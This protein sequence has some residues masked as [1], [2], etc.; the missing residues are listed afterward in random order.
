MPLLPS[1][2]ISYYFSLYASLVAIVLFIRAFL[3]N[4]YRFLLYLL[5]FW[6]FLAFLVSLFFP[7]SLSHLSPPHYCF[8]FLF[9]LV[10]H[11]FPLTFVS[12]FPT[13]LISY[14]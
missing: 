1:I 3:A 6:V 13:P 11:T 8:H 12:F 10:L 4:L 5:A 7:T 2:I 14:F 9:S